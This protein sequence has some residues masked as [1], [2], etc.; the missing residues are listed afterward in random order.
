MALPQSFWNIPHWQAL[1]AVKTRRK[2]E[3]NGV[4]GD[5]ADGGGEDDVDLPGG[6]GGKAK[7]GRRRHRNDEDDR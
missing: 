5:G 6:A 4:E 3:I 2:K 1:E 7:N